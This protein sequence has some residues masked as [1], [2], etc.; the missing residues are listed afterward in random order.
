MCNSEYKDLAE[1]N[2]IHSVPKLIVMRKLA[3]TGLLLLKL[4]MTDAQSLEPLDSVYLKALVAFN[5]HANG[6]KEQTWP[7]M[8]IGP[9][10]I[11]RLGGPLF[12]M[13]HPHPPPDGKQ[14]RDNIYMLK[15]E[16]LGIMGTSQTIIKDQLTA[17][18]NY[19]QPHYI[20]N[21]QFYAELFHELHHVYQ[22]TFIDK[23]QFDNPAEL[24]TYPEEY[25]NDAIKQYENELLLEMLSGPAAQFRTNLNMFFSCRK[26]R[27]EIIG[28]KY[29]GYEKHV[30][31][32]EGPATYCE[33]LYMKQFATSMAEREFI[34]K[35]FFYSLIEPTYGR[36]GLRNKHLLTGMIQCLILT[37][38]LKNN[39]QTE[40]YK[41]GLTLNDFFFKK[42]DPVKVNVPALDSYEAKTKYFTV[43]AK[44]KHN[45][46][47]RDF[48]SQA[49]VK[50]TLLFTSSPEFR[51]FDP[52]HAESLNDSLILHSTMLKLGKGD[53]SLSLAN[54]PVVTLVNGQVWFVKK[55]IFYTREDAIQVNN[56]K[57]VFNDG[58]SRI[59]WRF[60]KQVKQGNEY[61]FTAE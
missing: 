49:G 2:N 8:T 58:N 26:L 27:Q 31:S 3:L 29:A 51:G 41:S 53:N 55:V 4:T 39:W 34:H 14:L 16:D 25:R 20:S 28:S 44:E 1:S 60:I 40:Y 32:A 11:F 23:L 6:I 30:E 42:L 24:L 37:K 36:E 7:G 12:L 43:I 22:R 50:I 9:F 15:Q 10:C 52:M 61:I 46:R 33:Y 47:L 56:N 21:N 57:I 13:N 19:G 38:K 17:H 54:Y 45:Q 18:N 59:E 5:D 48:D 35:R